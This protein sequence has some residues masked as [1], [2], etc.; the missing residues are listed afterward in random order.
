VGETVWTK[1]QNETVHEYAF[2]GLGRQTA[3]KVTTLGTN[4]DGTV[5][6]ISREYEVRGMVASVA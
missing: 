5:R 4:V 3:D 2:D 1:D 6:R